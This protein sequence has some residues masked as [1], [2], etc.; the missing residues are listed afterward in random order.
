MARPKTS[1]SG[2][3]VQK[4]IENAFWQLMAQ[5]PYEKITVAEICNCAHINHN[6]IYY[7]YGSIDGM[8]LT[9]LDQMLDLPQLKKQAAHINND[10]SS[11]KQFLSQPEVN[12]RWRRACLF[13]GCGSSFLINRFRMRMVQFWL[14]L[15][16]VEPKY[17]SDEEQSRIDFL[18][19]GMISILANRDH[20]G[21]IDYFAD[22][23]T[24][25][26]F[27]DSMQELLKDLQKGRRMKN[28]IRK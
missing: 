27:F 28:E 7:H 24:K 22:V 19:G 23:L 17:L 2:S 12:Q 15:I 6:T 3:S 5:R 11:I 18:F 4:R 10:Q 8:A 26:H 14:Q 9:F 25:C 20:L 16:N 13:A 21:D 1:A